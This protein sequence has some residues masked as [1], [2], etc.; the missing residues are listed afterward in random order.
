MQRT[1]NPHYI[2]VATES[3]NWFD[4]FGVFSGSERFHTI[5]KTCNPS[6]LVALGYPHA[7]PDHL[8]TSMDLMNCF[9]L[10]D[11]TSDR[12]CAGDVAKG[13]AMIMAILRCEI[14]LQVVMLA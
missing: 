9:L 3:T 4:S 2:D 10:F 14:L 12:Q 8:R 7:S 11:E 6:L 5:F 13:A 1:I